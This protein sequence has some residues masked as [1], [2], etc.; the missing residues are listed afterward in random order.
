MQRLGYMILRITK[1]N[2]PRVNVPL[3][4]LNVLKKNMYVAAYE[5]LTLFHFVCYVV[6]IC[7]GM[8]PRK[9]THF[10]A[11]QTVRIFLTY[12]TWEQP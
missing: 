11:V 3:P 2:T 9:G 6:R 4:A 8:I 12:A 1:K 7:H 10:Q 5:I